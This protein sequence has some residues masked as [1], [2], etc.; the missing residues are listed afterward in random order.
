VTALLIQLFNILKKV[1]DN[2]GP[3]ADIVTQ[4]FFLLPIEG[5]D[6]LNQKVLCM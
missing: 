6:S 5:I 3:K 4:M 2:K 1:V